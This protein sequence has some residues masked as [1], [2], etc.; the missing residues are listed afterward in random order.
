M[1]S[2]RACRRTRACNETCNCF[3]R[4]VLR[5]TR[6][7]VRVAGELGGAVDRADTCGVTADCQRVACRCGNRHALFVLVVDEVDGVLLN[8]DGLGV[9]TLNNREV[10]GNNVA[11]RHFIEGR[12]A[13]EYNFVRGS[14][15]SEIA[16]TVILEAFGCRCCERCALALDGLGRCVEGTGN[17]ICHFTAPVSANQSILVLVATW[18]GHVNCLG[19]VA[20]EC[21]GVDYRII[22]HNRL[23]FAVGVEGNQHAEV[24][25]TAALP[26][27]R[28]GRVGAVAEQ[29]RELV[30]FPVV[31]QLRRRRGVVERVA[32]LG[33]ACRRVCA[34]RLV[35]TCRGL[36]FS[37]GKCRFAGNHCQPVACQRRGG[38]E[39]E[40]LTVRG[41]I[42]RRR[43]EN[44][45]CLKRGVCSRA[46]SDREVGGSRGVGQRNY[47]VAAREREVFVLL[48]VGECAAVFHEARVRRAFAGVGAGAAV[49]RGG[50]VDCAC[51]IQ[52]A[53]C[54]RVA[55]GEHFEGLT[56][57]G[58]FETQ[59]CFFQFDSRA[60]DEDVILG[61]AIC[62][63]GNVALEY[64]SLARVVVGD[65]SIRAGTARS[66][67]LIA[68][69]CSTCTLERMGSRVISLEGSILV[70][71]YRGETVED[72][73]VLLGGAVHGSRVVDAQFR[74]AVPGGVRQSRCADCHFVGGAV[75]CNRV[76]D[77]RGVGGEGDAVGD[78]VDAVGCGVPSRFSVFHVVSRNAAHARR[79]VSARVLIGVGT[80]G[81]NGAVGVAFCRFERVEVEG[82][83]RRRRDSVKRNARAVVRLRAESSRTDGNNVVVADGDVILDIRP[84]DQVR[85]EGDVLRFG[86]QGH[87]VFVRGDREVVGCITRRRVLV[88]DEPRH[89]VRRS[90]RFPGGRSER[91]SFQIVAE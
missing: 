33:R 80:E 86:L 41:G 26:S 67:N 38:V 44:R 78:E 4:A 39:C 1:I 10:V 27:E 13:A 74:A 66:S 22:Q 87:G 28:A 5:E 52:I 53:D 79:R 29:E 56:A 77:C 90:N 85:I 57:R 73:R 42:N 63:E 49:N 64:D 14:V 54:Q 18:H 50:F 84:E 31:G 70:A 55:V 48:V 37:V 12:R 36:Y 51:R 59:S 8:R 3:S 69:S 58:T 25:T 9:V 2:C 21:R 20:L 83:A 61:S 35:D 34:G 19:A 24:F 60:V 62:S 40:D 16:C 23:E 47:V 88:G 82:V 17:C 91:S 81:S 7:G 45:D 30:G 11:R 46:G 15:V 43:I 65:D 76:R 68:G 6:A 75:K 32:A 71:T 89:A 72:K